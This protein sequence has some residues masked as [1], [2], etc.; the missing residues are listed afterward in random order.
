[1][2]ERV[3]VRKIRGKVTPCNGCNR[4]VKCPMYAEIVKVRKYDARSRGNNTLTYCDLW[5]PGKI[6]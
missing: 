4:R 2:P 1:M 5:E 3:V 6:G